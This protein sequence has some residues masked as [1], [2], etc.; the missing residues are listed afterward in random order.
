MIPIERHRADVKARA[1]AVAPIAARLRCLPP[2]RGL[3]LRIS[4]IGWIIRT[5][6]RTAGRRAPLSATPLPCTPAKTQASS[7]NWPRPQQE[8]HQR[9][10]NDHDNIN[11]KAGKTAISTM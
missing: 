10:F 4:K 6:R 5:S 3:R 11:Q 9:N 2:R 8:Q 1:L 7:R